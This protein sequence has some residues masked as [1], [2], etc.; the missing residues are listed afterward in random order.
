MV[1]MNLDRP[2]T[3][4]IANVFKKGEGWGLFSIVMATAVTWELAEGLLSLSEG[5]LPGARREIE[6]GFRS[7]MDRVQIPA[8]TL[9]VCMT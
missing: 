7:Q 1:G 4:R 6:F 5:A 8:L 2:F 9:T 3:M